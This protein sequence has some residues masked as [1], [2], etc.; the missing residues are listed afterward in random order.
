MAKTCRLMLLFIFVFP[1]GS[2]VEASALH[3]GGSV[4]FFSPALKANV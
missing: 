1:C 2:L 4:F 3:C